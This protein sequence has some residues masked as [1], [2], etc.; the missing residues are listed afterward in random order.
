MIMINKLYNYVTF[1]HV[2]NLT[3]VYGNKN[4]ID[5][6]NLN[7]LQHVCAFMMAT[8]QIYSSMSM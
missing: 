5:E 1:S 3:T 7:I 2:P 6:D 4:L 8:K